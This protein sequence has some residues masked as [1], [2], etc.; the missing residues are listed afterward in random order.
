M[1]RRALTICFRYAAYWVCQG[2]ILTGVWVIAHECGHGGFSPSDLVNDI[3]GSICHSFLLVPYWSW[4]FSH[5]KVRAPALVI[6]TPISLFLKHHKNT[7]HMQGDEVFVPNQKK[8]SRFVRNLFELFHHPQSCCFQWR[9]IL[10]REPYRSRHPDIH[11]AHHWLA[12]VLAHKRD[13]TKLQKRRRKPPMGLPFPPQPPVPLL[14][15]WCFPIR[16]RPPL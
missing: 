9:W 5:A 16:L 2:C 6:S 7:G 3:V 14:L 15:P 8:S 13:G 4:K 1:L 11:H 12:A 10:F